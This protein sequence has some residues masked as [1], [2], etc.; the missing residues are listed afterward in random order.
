MSENILVFL[1]R[2][3]FTAAK[4]RQECL[5]SFSSVDLVGNFCLE[6]GSRRVLIPFQSWLSLNFFLRFNDEWWNKKINKYPEKRWKK[7][8]KNKLQLFIYLLFF[9]MKNIS[10]FFSFRLQTRYKSGLVFQRTTLFN[11]LW[12]EFLS[13]RE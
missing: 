11:T 7:Q 3:K 12:E 13:L 4:K 1:S 2:W 5:V 10:S 8:S 9:L 6:M